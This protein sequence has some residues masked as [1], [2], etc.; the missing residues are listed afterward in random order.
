[1]DDL[2]RADQHAGTPITSQRVRALQALAE[3]R[4]K[5]N[6]AAADEIAAA[7][8]ACNLAEAALRQLVRAHAA[9]RPRAS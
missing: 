5:S 4:A 3:E 2:L 8:A 1:M 7:V 9:K 6:A